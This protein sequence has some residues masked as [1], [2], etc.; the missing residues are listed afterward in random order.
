MKKTFKGRINAGNPH[1][2]R[3]APALLQHLESDGACGL[4]DLKLVPCWLVHPRRSSTNS[5]QVSPLVISRWSRA[6]V[7]AT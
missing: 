4:C 2:D 3:A 7:Q 1:Q 5:E 6:R